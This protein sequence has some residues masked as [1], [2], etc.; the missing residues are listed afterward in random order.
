MKRI[1]TLTAALFI[2]CSVQAQDFSKLIG[3]WKIKKFQYDSQ[4]DNA[5]WHNAVKKY[6]S[7]T[8]THFT[9][10]EVN[11][12]TNVTTTSIFGT[13]DIKDGVY[14]EH[15]LH[16]NKESAPMI[17]QSFYFALTF[18]GDD[19]IRTT[20]SFNGMKTSELW[21]RVGKNDTP[22][23]SIS[24]LYV[25][26][27]GDKYISLKFENTKES[28]LTLIPQNDILSIEVIKNTNATSL[29]KERGKNGVIILTLKEET[30]QETLKLLKSKGIESEILSK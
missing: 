25:I 7:Y 29:F 2:L 12:A 16:V 30:V 24:P 11:L 13:Y 6:K 8:P 5:E 18:E 26:D 3:T 19:K 17:G 27:N 23:S 10:T 14:T 20:G 9:V 1:L 4:S 21:E 28:P 15:I 22:I